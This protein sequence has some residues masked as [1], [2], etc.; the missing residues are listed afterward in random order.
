MRSA[1]KKNLST[2]EQ[3][4][5]LD[6][7]ENIQSGGAGGTV[8]PAMEM[9]MN[10]MF[11]ALP[12]QKQLELF[13]EKM[14]S[15]MI[16]CRKEILKA[17]MRWPIGVDPNAA[18]QYVERAF[19]QSQCLP[20]SMEVRFLAE[21]FEPT[22]SMI[23]KRLNGIDPQKVAWYLGGN[24]MGDIYTS[25]AIG[26]ECFY[27]DIIRHNFANMPYK[28]EIVTAGTT[29][30]AVGFVDLSFLFAAQI[31]NAGAG[32]FRFV[33]YERSA[34]CVAKTMVIWDI[35]RSPVEDEALITRSVLQIWYSS[36][37]EEGTL[38]IFKAAVT[39]LVEE[40][41]FRDVNN[42]VRH[43]LLY[44]KTTDGCHCRSLP[45]VR[46]L[47]AQRNSCDNSVLTSF[48]LCKDRIAMAKYELSGDF[49]VLGD[50]YCGNITMFDCPDG[51]PPSASS[52][53]IFG[54][55]DFN[56]LVVQDESISIIEC[57]E[58]QMLSRIVKLR[59]WALE[60]VVTVELHCKAIESAV[61]EIAALRPWTMS[62]SNVLDYFNPRRFHAIARACS[63][64]GDTIHF[65]YSMNWAQNVLGT[66]IFDYPTAKVRKE[67][68]KGSRNTQRIF[69]QNF[70]RNRR[71]RVPLPENP[72]N[73][74]CV[75]LC[76]AQY[77]NW[78]KYWFDEARASGP[79]SVA[80][81]EPIDVPLCNSGALSVYMSWTYDPSITFRGKHAQESG[82]FNA[83]LVS[84]ISDNR[85]SDPATSSASSSTRCSKCH[86]EESENVKLSVCG[87]CRGVR[88]CS[89]E[90][91]K[92]DWPTHKKL[93]KTMKK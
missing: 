61:E 80:C 48:L 29:H 52:E 63:V 71:V 12:E 18:K 70:A 3:Q 15:P 59:N 20:Y 62:W 85:S 87:G 47:W 68:L 41:G 77:K 93:C 23:V 75:V 57:A 6:K 88:Y 58:R 36:T 76:F 83:P 81:T 25:N 32:P 50:P 14:I 27:P 2:A 73:S 79:V 40:E 4:K 34:F 17:D 91:Q 60:G 19:L 38:N 1:S 46:K 39:R 42:E 82:I 45:E 90:C 26:N 43:I 72:I 86:K 37:W 21:E 30:V 35:L 92:M 5:I 9:M 13:G 78:T 22:E 49:G 55:V 74:S 10:T 7:C 84:G 8:S 24:N 54:A 64:H 28:K 89:K 33:G 65:A 67:I 16:D 66:Y 31:A 51:T 53:G 44:W 69:Y 56:A 11:L